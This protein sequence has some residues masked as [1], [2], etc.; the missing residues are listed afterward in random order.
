M[1]QHIDHFEKLFVVKEKLTA[2][3]FLNTLSF[4]DKLNADEENTSFYWDIWRIPQTNN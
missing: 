1:K 4:Q 3:I 2:T